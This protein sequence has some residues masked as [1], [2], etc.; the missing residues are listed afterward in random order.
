MCEWSGLMD[1]PPV[2]PLMLIHPQGMAPS[3]V[4]VAGHQS[5]IWPFQGSKGSATEALPRPCGIS[6]G[7]AMWQG[8]SQAR[9]ETTRDSTCME[10]E[11]QGGQ[12]DK[13]AS[14]ANQE[15]E[16]EFTCLGSRR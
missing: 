2:S 3:M 11:A 14:P 5:P 6:A 10:G 13:S 15:R 16:R 8:I 9:V 7:R 1:Q 4:E 12:Q